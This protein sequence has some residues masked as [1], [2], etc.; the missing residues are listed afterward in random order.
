MFIIYV[1]LFYLDITIDSMDSWCLKLLDTAQMHF[2]HTSTPV[3]VKKHFEHTST[4]QWWSRKGYVMHL[5][6]NKVCSDQEDKS[7]DK[8]RSEMPQL[9]LILQLM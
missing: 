2:E 5:F 8:N 1:H 9:D 7:V 6:V 4:P 3:M